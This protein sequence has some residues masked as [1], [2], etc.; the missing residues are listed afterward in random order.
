MPALDGWIGVAG[1]LVGAVWL[2]GPLVTAGAYLLS[3]RLITAQ[4]N[5]ERTA[6][7]EKLADTQRTVTAYTSDATALQYA[8]QE[9]DRLT[10]ALATERQDRDRL[11]AQQ[12]AQFAAEIARV[13]ADRDRWQTQAQLNAA[14]LY[15]HA[16]AADRVAE[17]VTQQT[18]LVQ[19]VAVAA[20]PPQ[21]TSE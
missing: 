16:G 10:T 1:L 12:A 17:A 2:I 18:A 15:K 9:I 14:T 20:A 19:A 6:L 3:I 7:L 5:R 13:I 4:H 8:G 21:G 11:L